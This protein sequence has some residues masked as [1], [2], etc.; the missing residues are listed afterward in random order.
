MLSSLA[1]CSII[2]MEKPTK[3]FVSII[4]KEHTN[5]KKNTV[6]FLEKAIERNF[7]NNKEIIGEFNYCSLNPE[8]KELDLREQSTL[9]STKTTTKEVENRRN[10]LLEQLDALIKKIWQQTNI[11]PATDEPEKYQN[12][13]EK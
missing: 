11:E 6:R 3:K 7:N 12:K 10:E 8:I 4:K 1:F 2:G 5:K 9:P 13:E